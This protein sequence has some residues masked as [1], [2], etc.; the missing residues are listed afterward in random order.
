MPS[1]A[2]IAA[3]QKLEA[4]FDKSYGEGVLST[5]KTT[6]ETISTGSVALD[7][8]MGAGGF[9]LG[10]AAEVWGPFS[11][12][13][14]ALCLGALGNA[15]RQYEEK[16]ASIVDVEHT[17]DSDWAKKLGVDTDYLKV[18]DP[19][20]A[21]DV[22]DMVKDM[23]IS[24]LYSM[25]VVDSVGAF[26]AKDEFEKDAASSA[27]GKR[28]QVLTR[29]CNI[30]GAYAK[31][32][33]TSV[34]FINQQRANLS[35]G[36][37]MQSSGANALKHVTSHKLQ[38]KQAS[39]SYTVGNEDKKIDVGFEMGV[40]VEKN[41]IAPRGRNVKFDFF[42]MDCHYDKKDRTVGID[43]VKDAWNAGVVNKVIAQSG[44]SYTLLDG[45]KVVGKDKGMAYLGEHP[46]MMDEIR[47][48]LLDQVSDE[49]IMDDG[50]EI[51]A[52]ALV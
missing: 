7:V 52:E 44:G 13:K 39:T 33:N 14:T 5:P 16:F 40:K 22:A 25:I 3:M 48:R 11:G 46:K 50:P 32:Y 1:K 10:R 17:Y 8:A 41:K 51:P 9:V 6:Y 26:L 20:T 18:V 19:T 45:T 47:I 21:E 37:G 30:V 12:G 29:M 43:R 4:Q 2:A 31:R 23:L 34:V 38:V 28:A 24:E 15:Q 36:G 42:T 49:L 27:M 35:F